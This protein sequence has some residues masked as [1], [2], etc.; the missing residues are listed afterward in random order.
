MHLSQDREMAIVV[1]K[2]RDAAPVVLRIDATAAWK[3]GLKFYHGNETIWL[4]N[5]IPAKYIS[6][7]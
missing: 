3:D 6:L 1:G 2:R 5:D 4:A 7:A